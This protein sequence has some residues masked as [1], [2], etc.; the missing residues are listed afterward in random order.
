VERLKVPANTLDR[1]VARGVVRHTTPATERLSGLLT[2][3]ADERTLL[4][5]SGAL[6]L[7]SRAAGDRRDPNRDCLVLDVIA[8]AVLPHLMKAVL[9]QRRPDRTVPPGR[10]GIPR[11][12][13]AYD[14]FPSGHAMHVGALASAASRVFPNWTGSIW[15]LAGLLAGTRI[16]LLAHWTTDVLAG[17]A[18]G[19]G[20][21]RLIAIANRKIGGATNAP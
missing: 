11:S 15:S 8:T 4:A 1:S 5:V 13:K 20:V 6:W 10:H 21:D 19:V 12:G 17:L 14:A 18:M 16:V 7:L 3:L 2:L 9:A